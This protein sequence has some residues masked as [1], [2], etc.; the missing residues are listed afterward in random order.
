MYPRPAPSL[1]DLSRRGPS[2]SPT[3]HPRLHL[4]SGPIAPANWINV[5]KSSTPVLMRR[6]LLKKAL[7]ASGIFTV[8]QTGSDWPP[9]ALRLDVTRQFPWLDESMEAIY[10]AHMVEHLTGAA[11]RSAAARSRR[12]SETTRRAERPAHARAGTARPPPSARSTEQSA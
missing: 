10:S 7:V 2:A 12:R 11:R 5:D 9:T 6:P 8:S 1:A 3:G 4:G